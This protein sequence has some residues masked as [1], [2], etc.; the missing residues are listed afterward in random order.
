MSPNSPQST[1][2]VLLNANAITTKNVTKE[3]KY[4]DSFYA[5]VESLTNPSQFGV[6]T[7][8]EAPKDGA[9]VEFGCGNGRDSIHLASKGFSVHACDLSREATDRNQSKVGEMNLAGNLA[10]SCVDATNAEQV[11]GIIDQARS[12]SQSKNLTVYTRFFLHSIDEDQ[13]GLFLDALSSALKANDELYFEFRC[14]ED[15]GLLKV[16]G[17]DHY[18]R[19]VETADLLQR[20]EKRGFDPYYHVTGRGM[21]KYKNEDPFVSRIIARKTE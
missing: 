14:K 18:R 1:A 17:T 19:Y 13:E 7:S 5:I 9:I 12:G 6:L 4:W 2:E 8:S 15:E 16:H 21:A 20:L 3:K 10:F 11:G